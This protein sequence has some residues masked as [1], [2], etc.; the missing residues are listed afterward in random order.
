MNSGA[1][2]PHFTAM[3]VAAATALSPRTVRRTLET[4]PHSS[5]VLVNGKETK[6][7]SL[8]VFEKFFGPE[9][10]TQRAAGRYRDH[11]SLLSSSAKPTWQPALPLAA[12]CEAQRRKAVKLQ[13]AIAPSWQRLEQTGLSAGEFERLGVNDY[14]AEFGVRISDRH[15]RELCKRTL[16]RDGG[17]EDWSRLEIYLDEGLRRA[18][19]PAIAPAQ[20]EFPLI[21]TTLALLS[22][23]AAPTWREMDLIW[24][25]ALHTLDAVASDA[26]PAARFK[27][28]ILEKLLREVP[29]L[30]HSYNSARTLF[31]GKRKAWL[32]GGKTVAAIMDR[33]YRDSRPGA[34][35][36]AVEEE[37]AGR[38]GFVAG[39]NHGGQLAPAFREL[40]AQG[41]ERPTRSANK[42]YVPI[43]LRREARQ[44]ALIVAASVK[45]KNALRSMVPTLSADPSRYRVHDIFTYDD[46]TLPILWYV[47]DGAGWFN[48]V[49]GQCLVGADWRSWRV[50]QF[51][52]QPDSQYNSKVI[53]TLFAKTFAAH[54]LP[55]ELKL[56]GGM[57]KSASLIHGNDA[58]RKATEAQGLEYTDGDVV[59]GLQTQLGIKITHAISPTGKTQIESI[60]RLMQDYL[61]P[62]KGYCGRDQ[63]KDLPDKIKRQKYQVETRQAHPSEFFYSF[64]QLEQRMH[65]VF[66]Q[67]NATPQQGD[68]LKNESPDEAF[69][70]YQNREDPP[71]AFDARCQHLLACQVAI[72]A[73][74]SDHTIRFEIGREKFCYFSQ[75]LMEMPA[76]ARIMV[77]FDPDLPEVITVTDLQRQNPISIP[78][79]A[80]TYTTADPVTQNELG[81]KSACASYLRARFRTL[82]AKHKPVVRRPIVSPATAELGAQI[83]SQRAALVTEEKRVARTR[84]AAAKIDLHLTPAA[85]RNA[86]TPAALEA[87]ERFLNAD[88]SDESVESPKLAGKPYVLTAPPAT[89]LP[90]LHAQFWGLWN[91][92]EK[93]TPGLNRHA[94]THKALGY[95]RPVK[96]MSAEEIGRVMQVLS[97]IARDAQGKTE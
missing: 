85:R 88:E 7:W 60:F 49:Q 82:E 69:E 30:A 84:R 11:L 16:G 54:G 71:I 23:K 9:L 74:K 15:W 52:L 38:L 55:K 6:A 51:S 65:Q 10:A 41:L 80:R 48:L 90:A 45:N 62:D 63:R 64:E 20:P 27:R 28:A 5:L 61:W 17:A 95:V 77:H 46:V 89:S 79:S 19:R 12:V 34:A 94:I 14:A 50:L 8:G 31:D 59:H 13:R 56:E 39:S 33:R 22:D 58:K 3:Q 66:T 35:P 24:G 75:P 92:V 81:K 18:P 72:R 25:A 2:Q 47:P 29:S 83:E 67:Y 36:D 42:S 73:L 78:R 43:A 40:V 87:L 26:A 96:E 21:D 44:D 97:A 4:V 76:G 32:A 1:T 91:R 53:R 68:W 86:E 70:K 57:W 93:L 37:R